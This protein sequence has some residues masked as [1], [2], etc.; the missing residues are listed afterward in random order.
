MGQYGPMIVRRCATALLFAG[1]AV[2]ATATPAFAHA[3]LIA[4]N[5]A[6]DASLATAP[7]QVELTFNAPVTL[8]AIPVAVTGPGG[9]S[10]AVGPVL[11]A[12]AVVTAPV[13]PVGPA[14]AYTLTYRVVSEDG[15]E[16][17]GTVP[18]TLTTPA[19]PPTTTTQPTTN[20]PT[21]PSTPS[22]PTEPVDTASEQPA[23]GG[24]PTWLWILVTVATLITAGTLVL[25]FSHQR[26]RP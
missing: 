2:V 25:T 4:S 15:D 1:V 20:T 16:V 18:F 21:T 7:T 17:T 9:E 11:V 10:W 5:P 24:W 8:A 13:Q 12:G 23:D 14:G 22:T 6:R 26:K 19:P 3:E